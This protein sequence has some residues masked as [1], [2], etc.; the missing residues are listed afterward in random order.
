MDK[1]KKDSVLTIRISKADKLKLKQEAERLRI[2]LSK[3]IM[4]QLPINR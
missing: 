4:Q 1:K 2:P 3:M